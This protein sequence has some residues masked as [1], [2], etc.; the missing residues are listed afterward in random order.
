LSA[1]QGELLRL[2]E[3]DAAQASTWPRFVVIAMLTVMCLVRSR[4][5][6]GCHHGHR[7]H[8]NIR[9]SVDQLPHH[10]RKPRRRRGA[11]AGARSSTHPTRASTNGSSWATRCGPQSSPGGRGRWGRR[12]RC[13]LRLLSRPGKQVAQRSRLWARDCQLHHTTLC[14][15]L[16]T[17]MRPQRCL[18]PAF[19]PHVMMAWPKRGVPAMGASTA[20]TGGGRA[21]AAA[22]VMAVNLAPLA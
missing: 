22:A 9:H 17:V 2:L 21:A 7:A 14:A 5:G 12:R 1:G 13:R 19:C 16:I 15:C 6:A 10:R 8:S 20:H 3:R 4:L 18:A 11:G